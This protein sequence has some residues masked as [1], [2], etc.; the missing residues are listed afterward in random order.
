MSAVR[1]QACIKCCGSVLSRLS[2]PV[3]VNCNVPHCGCSSETPSLACQA[4]GLWHEPVKTLSAEELADHRR[5]AVAAETRSRLIAAAPDLLA[6]ADLVAGLETPGERAER[7]DGTGEEVD[8][9]DAL[10]T[11][12]RLIEKARAAIA[13]AKG[14]AK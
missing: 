10:E 12:T 9:D 8:S 3:C 11:L 1:E 5:T 14:G 13:A 6:F 7:L 2:L 4:E